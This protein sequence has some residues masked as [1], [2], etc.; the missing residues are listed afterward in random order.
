MK[1]D[2]SIRTYT[3]SHGAVFEFRFTVGLMRK[4]AKPPVSVDLL[5]FSDGSQYSLQVSDTKFL[6]VVAAVLEIA[7]DSH[8]FDELDEVRLKD[9]R[10][11]FWGG[12]GFFIQTSNPAKWEMIVKMMDQ[13]EKVGNNL[14]E[15]QIDNLSGSTSSKPLDT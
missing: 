3:D 14:V 12:L 4:L 15:R 6:S 10:A 11:A 9:L 5:D 2:T 13:V 1:I 8:L 7:E